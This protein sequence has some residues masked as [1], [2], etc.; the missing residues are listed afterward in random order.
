MH[1]QRMVNRAHFLTYLNLEVL[2]ALRRTIKGLNIS[3]LLTPDIY[4]IRGGEEQFWT[5]LYIA[6]F[7]SLTYE[8]HY[9]R[10]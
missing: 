5:K 2:V 3:S 7:D 9:Y 1:E 8:Y 6:A 4:G 10:D